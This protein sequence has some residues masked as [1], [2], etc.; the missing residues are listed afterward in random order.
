MKKKTVVGGLI[1]MGTVVAILAGKEKKER[2]VSCWKELSNKHFMM[3]LLFNQWI[4]IKKEGKNVEDYFRKKN[5]NV[6]A[7]YGISYVGER[8]YEE[9]IDSSIEVKYIIDENKVGIY[10]NIPIVS[11]SDNIEEI[12]AVIVTSC[13]YFN[14]IKER[15]ALKGCKNVLSIED[16]IYEL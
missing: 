1:A 11:L 2:E 15:L 3:I 13:F 9:L 4:K 14:E 16:I 12:D 5:I 7:I 8:L 6:I 10:E